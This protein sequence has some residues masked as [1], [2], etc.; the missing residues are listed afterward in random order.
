MDE[1]KYAQ[2]KLCLL[3]KTNTDLNRDNGKLHLDVIG[4]EKK[5]MAN[6]FLRKL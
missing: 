2:K 4:M 5:L 1:N 6:H 3:Q